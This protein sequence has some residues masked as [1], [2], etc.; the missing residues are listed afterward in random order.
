[1]T[2]TDYAKKRPNAVTDWAAIVQ[3]AIHNAG[4]PRSGG[5]AQLLHTYVMLAVYDAVMAIE[6]G[7]EPY[8]A[9]ID[10]P[11]H[12][13]VRAAVATAAYLTAR[14][15]V[16][17]SQYNYL[18]GQYAAYLA[19]ISDGERKTAGIQVGEQAS[20]EILA[21]RA[22]DGFDTV[23]P[24]FC[25]MVPPPVGEF[26]PDTG[27]P[28][29]P[30]DPQPADA[31]VALIRPF[32]YDDPDRFRTSGPSSLT[33][34]AYTTDFIETRDYGRAGSTV[35]T[36]EQTDVA[37]F[38][39]E[40]PYVFWNRNLINLALERGL[41][42]RESARFFAMVYTTTSDSVIAGFATKYFYTAWRPRT[43]IPQAD[44][45][46]NPDTPADPT[47]TPLLKVN[48]PEYPSGHGFWSTALTDAV[49][50]F[51]GTRNIRWTLEASAPNVVQTKRT[52]RDLDSVMREVDDARVWGGLHWRQS[53]RHGAQIGHAVARHVDRYFFNP[54]RRKAD[55]TNRD[56]YEP[57]PARLAG[58]D[59]AHA[60]AAPVPAPALNDS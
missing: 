30:T 33:S 44:K 25:S 46:G 58:I 19:G 28:T 51:F 42:V 21:L 10:A 4:A 1:M 57:R 22:G 56:E 23:V 6:G 34:K 27:C 20:A 24:Y 50:A 53:M 32:T 40:H 36:P 15:R 17:M 3:P 7:Y 8:A 35:R 31:K 9:D 43:A 54:T 48:H 14:A 59:A 5:T 2:A 39:S 18:D 26:E 11:R 47:W 49:G 41:N 60:R 16:A 12:A 45:D 55:A 29:L 13:D 52:Y 38:W 37:Y